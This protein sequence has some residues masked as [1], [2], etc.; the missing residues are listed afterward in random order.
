MKRFWQ[1]CPSDTESEGKNAHPKQS[2]Q[3]PS[4]DDEL[5]CT[6]AWQIP[7][8]DSDDDE[9]A[10]TCSGVLADVAN[11]VDR[12]L[13][14][15]TRDLLTLKVGSDRLPRDK[16]SHFENEGCSP[17]RLKQVLG[18]KCGCAKACFKEMSFSTVMSVCEMFHS[19]LTASERM[20]F[21]ISI[22]NQS[23]ITLGDEDVKRR[24][25]RYALEGRGA[26]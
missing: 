19:V 2:W 14:N 15:I 5:D 20:A 6:R 3:C 1:A 12:P 26:H 16:L 17:D 18:G 23:F 21:L 9:L 13:V 10:P 7:G 25:Q 22:M 8:S 11:V 24:R 4:S